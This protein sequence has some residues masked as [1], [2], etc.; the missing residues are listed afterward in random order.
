[1]KLRDLGRTCGSCS[2]SELML[3]I[4]LSFEKRR[5]WRFPGFTFVDMVG[6]GARL[7]ICSVRF[8]EI[9]KQRFCTLSVYFMG[10]LC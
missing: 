6:S 9:T 5:V 7:P 3:P 4:G 2:A 8:T 1:M 10:S